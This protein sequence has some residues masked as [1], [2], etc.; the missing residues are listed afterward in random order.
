MANRWP[1]NAGSGVCE[2][3]HSRR[4]FIQ[5]SLSVSFERPAPSGTKS[6]DGR[7]C[8]TAVSQTVKWPRTPFGRAEACEPRDEELGFLMCRI[9][10]WVTGLLVALS[11]AASSAERHVVVITIDGLPSYLL[12]DPEASLPVI[13]GLAA[14]GVAAKQGMRVSNPSVTWP[15]HTTLMT[16]VHPE[17]HGVLFNGALE[18][19]APGMPVR[20]VS[21]KEQKELV[22]VPLLFDVLKDA[23][24]TSAAINWPC[25]RG[26]TSLVDN[27][28]DVPRSLEYSSAELK[29]E[30]ASRGVLDRFEKGGGVVRDEIWAEAACEAIR[31]RRPRLLALHLLNLDSTHHSYGPKSGP[32]YTAA[33]LTDALVGRVLKT[34]DD[35]GIRDQT[36]VFVIADHGFSKV[37]KSIHPNV[38]LRRYGLLKV[39]GKKVT[40]AKAQ[41][42]SEGG[43]GMVFLTDPETAKHDRETVLSLFRRAEGVAAILEPSDFARYHLPMPGDHRGMADLILVAEPGYAVNASATAEE[44]VAKHEPVIG[45]HGYLS[46]SPEMNAIF[47]ASGPGI[48]KGETV[49][50]VDNVD[51]APTAAHLLGVSLT[52]VSGRVLHEILASTKQ[53][54]WVAHRGESVDAPENTM[55]AF[56]LAWERKDPAIEL[57]VHLSKDGGLIVSHDDDT[58]RTTGESKKIKESSTDELR[59]LDAGQW[60]DPRWKG[61]KLPLLEEV[62]ATI[63]DGGRCFIEIK[64]GPEAVAPLVEAVKKSGKKP[65][66]LVIISFQADTVAEAKRK[67]PELKAYYLAGFKRGKEGGWQPKVED[68][69]ERAREIHADGLDLSYGPVDDE[70]VRKIHGAGLGVYVWTVDSP[71]EARRLVKAGVDGITT[72][73]PAWM[74]DQLRESR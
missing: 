28:P 2:P 9:L 74:K 47:V 58:K 72:N 10:C 17:R 22:R 8:G 44:F 52:G 16:G 37:A 55:A 39:E 66:Q 45:A 48:K 6:L 25:T 13:R 33:A 35:V 54:E 15:N 71:D 27:F 23:G 11:S 46:T 50:V 40:A 61:E 53:V 14:S 41:V 43:I 62:L 26:S 65:E 67:L 56:R 24:L 57:D 38:L 19:S 49:D 21:E 1:G 30:L 34:L 7:L 42:I 63:P 3:A 64:V 29:Q 20:L 31:S 60:K 70:M 68:L 4:F 36:D 59:L 69:I 5:V 51:V 73:K 32:G 12:N 18:R